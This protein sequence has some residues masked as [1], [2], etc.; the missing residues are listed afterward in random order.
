[1]NKDLQTIK[2]KQNDQERDFENF[3][4]P[5]GNCDYHYCNGGAGIDELQRDADCY[6]TER[7]MAK[8]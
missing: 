6:D 8:G 1:M 7:D 2:S 5:H 4:G 3:R